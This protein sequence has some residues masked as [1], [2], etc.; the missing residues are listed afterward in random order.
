MV[1]QLINTDKLSDTIYSDIEKQFPIEERKSKEE[2]D[3]L[4]DGGNYKLGLIYDNET[5]IGYI[6]YIVK[7]FVWIDYI[8]VMKDFHSKG[9][10][11]EILRTLFEKYSA[12]EGCYF[13]VEPAV[14]R[15]PHTIRR[16]NFYKKLGCTELNFKYYFPNHVKKLELK[17]LYKSFNGTIPDTEKIKKDIKYV[18]DIIHSNIKCKDE[19]FY[20]INT[21]NP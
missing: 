16:M 17:L 12:L 7:N 3:K 18:F 20:L 19:I 15:H 10:G 9:Y 4:L 1:L 5:L 21:E 13:E 8:A 6:F 14:N 2:F 11:S